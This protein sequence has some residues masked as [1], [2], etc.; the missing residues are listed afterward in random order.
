LRIQTTAKLAG[1]VGLAAAVGVA[2]SDSG[3]ESPTISPASG[4]SGAVG[5][6][7]GSGSTGPSGGTVF[8]TGGADDGGI[9]SCE[10][11][12]EPAKLTPVNLV[13]MID[14]SGSMGDQDLNG[15]GFYDQ[16]NEWQNTPFRW[17]PVKEALIAFFNDPGEEGLEASIE[18]FPDGS[19]PTGPDTGVCRMQ[20]YQNPAAPM[21][22]LD[23]D[24]GRQML[25]TRL[26][27]TTPNGGTPTLPALQG[28]IEY[29]RQTMTENPG[30]KSVVVLVTDGEP[31]VARIEDGVAYNEKCFCY[32]QPGCPDENEIPYVEQAAQAAY[33]EGILTYVI[34]MGEVDPSNLDTIAYA[35]ANQPAFIVSTGDPAQTRAMFTDALASIRSV[36]APC[37]IEMPAPPEGENFD[38]ELVNVEFATNTG[39]TTLAYAGPFAAEKGGLAA[40]PPADSANPWYWRYDSEENPTKIILCDSACNATQ[41]DATG[42]VNVKYGCEIVIEVY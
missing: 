5:A 41:G 11:Q 12:T 34:G 28:A 18:F 42:R 4:G 40:C 8:A 1:I 32:G 9:V 31:G 6:T 26:E 37:E 20:Q 2:C 36:Q 21:T 14:K 30:S 35:G 33:D 23:D 38:K 7:F 24:V 25:I 16:A 27:N 29:A 3:A 39:A 17:D 19:Q 22:P 15:D 13:F 10:D